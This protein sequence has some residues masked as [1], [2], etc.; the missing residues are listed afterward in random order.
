MK[1]DQPKKMK[2]HNAMQKEAVLA[3]CMVNLLFSVNQLH[4]TH[5]LTLKNHHHVLVGELYEELEEEL[6]ELA[7]QYLGACLPEIKPEQALNIPN[8]VKTPRFFRAI[9]TEDE[10]LA[11]IHEITVCATMALNVVEEC[12]KFSFMRDTLMDIIAVLH[13]KKYQI[14]QE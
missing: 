4:L 12:K 9:K 6:D 10:I 7:E 3:E 5:W 11:V 14:T 1:S 2:K 13:S 8:A